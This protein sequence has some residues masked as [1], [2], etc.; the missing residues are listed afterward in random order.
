MN[1]LRTLLFVLST[2]LTLSVAAQKPLAE[3]N[4]ENFLGITDY[5]REKA[6]FS[7]PTRQLTAYFLLGDTLERATSWNKIA[8]NDCKGGFSTPI[9][10]DKPFSQQDN[11]LYAVNPSLEVTLYCRVEGLNPEEVAKLADSLRNTPVTLDQCTTGNTLNSSQNCASY[12]LECVLRAEGIDPA[13]F[14]TWET[15]VPKE[16]FTPLI[17]RLLIPRRELAI[18]KNTRKW[19]RETT[20]TPNALYVCYDQTGEPIHLFFYRDG[21]FWSKNGGV[22]AHVSYGS[23]LSILKHYSS[24]ASLIEYTLREL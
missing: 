6:V 23:I 9:H 4:G 18:P 2:G 19:A 14:F 22:F 12:A 15:V 7:E 20:F 3:F 5:K 24:T 11:T 10:I 8:I 17:E 16:S 1:A 21:R 13:P